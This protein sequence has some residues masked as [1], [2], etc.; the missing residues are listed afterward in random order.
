MYNTLLSD[1]KVNVTL[2]PSAVIM[3]GRKIVKHETDFTLTT[4]TAIQRGYSW[5]TFRN[6][7][8]ELASSFVI[9]NDVKKIEITPE[10]RDVFIK[11]VLLEIK[12]SQHF[13]PA[14][15]KIITAVSDNSE[16]VNK[17]LKYVKSQLAKSSD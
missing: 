3:T 4:Y 11:N 9:L 1:V 13:F 14:I 2:K 5:L 15:E 10:S 7:P 16:D 8:T 12:N 17:L 6:A